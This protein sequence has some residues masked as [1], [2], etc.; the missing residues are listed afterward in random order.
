MSIAKVEP[1]TTARALRGP[2]DYRLPERL[3]EVGVGTVLLVPFG[4]RRVL[5]VVVE[6]AER[7]ALAP[8]RLAEP[9]EA[10]E[11]G[12]P[13]RADPARALGRARVLL[14]RR[15]AGSSWCCRR[16]P[17]A[18]AGR[19]E[20]AASR[21][22]RRPPPPSDAL[23]R[24][25][26]DRAS[27]GR[28]SCSATSGGELRAADLAAE[29]IGRDALLRLERRGLVRLG[30]REVRRRPATARVGAPAARV[31]LDAE[32]RAAV[33]RIVAG[34]D[35]GGGEL[36]LHG[37][38]GSGKTEVYLAAAEAAL[39]RGRGAI[40]LVPEIG[41]DAAGAGA[42]RLALRRP[43]RGPALAARRR[44]AARRVAAA[45]PRRGADLRRA[46][47]RRSSRRSPGSG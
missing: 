4:S 5:G 20:R 15:R 25:V 45:A 37:V 16:G 19:R 6:L 29:G 46:R 43:G 21:W 23:A 13:A 26:S 44:R 1:L 36:L 30:E 2:F 8:E 17:R 22:S 33:E 42:L 10:L 31:S 11:A 38:T 14:D 34:L 39:E 24:P 28:S 9:I 40:V 27:G 12:A 32:Q 7:S 18:R 35:G 3:G 47:A 41:D